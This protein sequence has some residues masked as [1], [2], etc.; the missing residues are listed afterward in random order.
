MARRLII[1]SLNMIMVE[2]RWYFLDFAVAGSVFVWAEY[3]RF[4][5]V[6]RRLS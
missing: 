6:L 2:G 3:F 5:V 4:D 1:M